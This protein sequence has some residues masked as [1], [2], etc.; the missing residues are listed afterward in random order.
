[1]LNTTLLKFMT[2]KGSLISSLDNDI[3]EGLVRDAVTGGVK[4]SENFA[5][6]G[7]ILKKAG[8]LSV[9]GFA[10][11]YLDGVNGAF[12]AGVNNKVFDD[13]INKTY[14]PERY[15]EVT[16]NYLSHLMSGFS[17]AIQSTTD[18]QNIYEGL[19][20]AVSPFA[21]A[22]VNVP[23]MV[24]QPKD[25]WRAILGSSKG[26]NWTERA[27]ALINNPFITEVGEMYRKNRT[28]DERVATINSMIEGS[29]GLVDDMS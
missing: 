7:N 19:I 11:E 27:S 13:Y 25:T 23:G 15:S 21:S 12:G 10:D 16:D 26:L 2:G 1:M 17:E 18:W 20:G 29:K 14:N 24:A 28:V 5:G 3:T 8:K 4:R 22:M 6:A 9:G